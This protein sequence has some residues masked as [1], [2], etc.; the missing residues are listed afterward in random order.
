MAMNQL[1]TVLVAIGVAL[2]LGHLAFSSRGDSSVMW[3]SAYG[4]LSMSFGILLGV[5]LILGGF[6]RTGVI[7]VA[8]AYFLARGNFERFQSERDMRAKAANR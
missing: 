8:V 4:T 7:V 1:L 6:M 3:Y 2:A 5:F